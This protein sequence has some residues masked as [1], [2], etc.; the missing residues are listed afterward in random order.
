MVF[1]GC[2]KKDKSVKQKRRF[3]QK[4]RKK[5]KEEREILFL[6]KPFAVLE[7]TELL[8]GKVS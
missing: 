5:S 8:G 2:I 4:N 7:D 3:C 6:L 1:V